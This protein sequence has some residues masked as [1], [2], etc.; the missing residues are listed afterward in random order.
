MA[1]RANNSPMKSTSRMV[2]NGRYP[3]PLRP[4][5]HYLS[6]LPALQP[7][8]PLKLSLSTLALCESAQE[9]RLSRVIYGALRAQGPGQKPTCVEDRDWTHF[10]DPFIDPASIPR[11]I[12]FLPTSEMALR[13]SS[14]PDIAIASPSISEVLSRQSSPSSQPLN[15]LQ[16]PHDESPAFDG[17]FESGRTS[18]SQKQ[19]LITDFFP[20]AVRTGAVSSA[21]LSCHVQYGEAPPSSMIIR[22]L[23]RR[24]D[25]FPAL[26]SLSDTD[27]P[28]GT[29]Q[30]NT[31]PGAPIRLDPESKTMTTPADLSQSPRSSPLVSFDETKGEV[32]LQPE[33]GPGPTIRTESRTQFTEL[34]IGSNITVQLP[35]SAELSNSHRNGSPR[36]PSR[37]P[38]RRTPTPASRRPVTDHG[39][40]RLMR[41]CP[42]GELGNATPTS[43][44]YRSGPR[45]EVVLRH[46]SRQELREVTPMSPSLPSSLQSLRI[47]PGNEQ[48]GGA[49][50]MA[51]ET[52]HQS[53]A[54]L[55]EDELIDAEPV[56]ADFSV[57]SDGVAA[58]PLAAR[59]ATKQSTSQVLFDQPIGGTPDGVQRVDMLHSEVSSRCEMDSVERGTERQVRRDVSPLPYVRSFSAATTPLPSV[60][61]GGHG[62]LKHERGKQH[63]L[64]DLKQSHSVLASTRENQATPRALRGGGI[65]DSEQEPRKGNSD[66]RMARTTQSNRIPSHM[67]EDGLTEVGNLREEVPRE[68]RHEQPQR[69]NTASRR[70]LGMFGRE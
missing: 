66:E 61:S 2:L 53:P 55:S 21:K 26:K 27:C 34:P 38:T 24:I 50:A 59:L 16:A 17:L 11:T 49:M 36:R 40:P 12:S 63:I 57:R 31:R 4:V 43:S 56:R 19:A 10:Q 35:G 58:S 14:R 46:R 39:P 18:P 44:P 20:P 62:A 33:Y 7:V 45:R 51:S 64:D 37:I 67:S 41:S 52:P 68:T 47:S 29:S 42:D 60:L 8:S 22:D 30:A 28:G 69:S 65:L 32:P 48:G 25:Q 3:P 70:F 15:Q 13:V 6:Y 54:I 9:S 1:W 5:D 23:H